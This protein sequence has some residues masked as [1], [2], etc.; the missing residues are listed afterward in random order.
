MWETR[1]TSLRCLTIFV[2]R[3]VMINITLWTPRLLRAAYWVGYVL[4]DIGA[5][6]STA[7]E[8]WTNLPLGG[9]VDLVEMREAFAALVDNGLI[10]KMGGMLVPSDRLVAAC[11]AP[12]G[13][14]SE[15][16]LALIV[17]AE[18]PLWLTTSTSDGQVLLRE[19]IPDDALRT[20]ESVIPD[21]ARR[22]AFLLARARVV[23]AEVLKALGQCGEI[24]VADCCRRE[25]KEAGRP[26]LA[27]RVSRVS[28]VSDELGYD[29]TAPRLDGSTRRLEVKT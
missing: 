16:M 24:F 29:I 19:L 6:E 7:R 10:I 15:I 20:L 26:E 21:A 11:S 13:E 18:R 23:E 9:R 12:S 2:V 17:E 8:S 14:A 1:A 27:E 3:I 25:L 28:K 22:E 5:D 4:G